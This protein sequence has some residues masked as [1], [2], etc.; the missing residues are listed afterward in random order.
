MDKL[1]AP[2][3]NAILGFIADTLRSGKDYS[4][5]AQ[6]PKEVPL[7]GG[8]G[9][10]DILFGKSPEFVDDVSYNPRSAI[11]GGNRAT[12]GLGTYTLD[13]RIA[14]TAFIGLDAAGVG[15]VGAAGIKKLSDVAAKEY[16]ERVL[17]GGTKESRR[18]FLKTTGKTATLA[19][20][21]TGGIA[22]VRKTGKETAKV[23]PKVADNAAVQATKNYK[24]N[25]LKEYLDDVEARAYDEAS[26]GASENGLR[27]RDAEDYI[28]E[29]SGDW[30]KNILRRDEVDYSQGKDL[31]KHGIEFKQNG[32]IIVKKDGS[33]INQATLDY[34][35][36]KLEEFSPQAKQEM[37][38]FK[39]RTKI[40]D[41]DYGD[42]SGNSWQDWLT[43]TDDVTTTLD[44]LRKIT[45]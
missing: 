8:S 37:K 33:R 15:K 41:T 14:D 38:E 43:N 13:P 42:I 4:N 11:R 5:R 12:G 32:D 2:E 24:F 23:A 6:I 30:T 34:Y 16:V 29:V 20:I 27:G 28:D 7:L 36:N 3:R 9:L 17:K 10:G 44:Y 31:F 1:S 25:S 40:L 26:I 21:G 18:E 22:A 39:T 35:G 45:K 19:A